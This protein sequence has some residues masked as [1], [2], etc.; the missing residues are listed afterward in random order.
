MNSKYDKL[1]KELSNKSLGTEFENE[2]C[3][4]LWNKGYWVHKF[5]ANSAGQPAD[6]IAVKNGI[7]VLIDCKV[8]A[9]DTFKMSRIESN[10]HTA[11]QHWIDCGNIEVGFAFKTNMGIFLVP[12]NELKMWHKKSI[13]VDE[14]KTIGKQ[15]Q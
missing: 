9:D 1:T 2:F 15:I 6:I 8:C 12:Y 5:V 10:Q 4:I 14:I 3:E 7:A 11:M 13:T